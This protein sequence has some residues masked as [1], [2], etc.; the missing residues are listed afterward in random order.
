MVTI[1]TVFWTQISSFVAFVFAVFALYRLLVDQKDATIQ[2]LKENISYLKDQLADAKQQSPDVL[3]ERLAKRT[4]M[5][6]DELARL[7][8]DKSA[9]EAEINAKEAELASARGEAEALTRKVLH[10]RE[11]LREYQC[12]HCGS[13]LVE[14]A[15]H[16]ESVEYQGR[17]IDVD[18]DWSTFECGLEIVDGLEREGCRVATSL[19][20][21]N[22]NLHG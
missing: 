21:Q 8:D 7:S 3:A 15:Y 17:E 4:K 1:N 5:L 19:A 14:R 9:T 11:L 10:A 2:S 22:F 13:P 18:H 16:S 6:E 20:A 12:P